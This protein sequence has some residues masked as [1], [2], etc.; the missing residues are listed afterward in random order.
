MDW[1]RLSL[2]RA[3]PAYVA[4]VF[5]MMASSTATSISVIMH[6][7]FVVGVVLLMLALIPV[8][9]ISIALIWLQDWLR[10]RSA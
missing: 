8:L 6:L 7:A 4:G 3:W 10:R 1:G 9:V 5:A 2:R